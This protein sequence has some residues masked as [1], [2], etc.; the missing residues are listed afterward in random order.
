MR[1]TTGN[2]DAD[3]RRQPALKY[4][5]TLFAVWSSNLLYAAFVSRYLSI[6]KIVDNFFKNRFLH[7]KKIKN[8]K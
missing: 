5:P 7:F 4:T 2:D 1:I 6:N 8:Y 3:L